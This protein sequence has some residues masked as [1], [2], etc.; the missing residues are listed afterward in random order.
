MRH[1]VADAD[2]GHF[3]VI[4]S[5]GTSA[6]HAG[7]PPD[8][9]STAAAALHGVRLGGQSRQFV[10]EDFDRFD[11]I[12][13][14]DTQN[15]RNLRSLARGPDDLARLSLLRQWRP[16]HD[17]PDKHVTADVPD[18]YYDADDG[19]ETVFRICNVACTAILATLQ[20]HQHS[21]SPELRQFRASRSPAK[22]SDDSV[23]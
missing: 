10:V 3:V 13:A 23:F 1:L 18:P 8:R 5:A 4:D 9:R 2:I 14:M 22:T 15:L 19:F 7:D 17:G 16:E 11:H 20:R 12:I 21:V 6:Y